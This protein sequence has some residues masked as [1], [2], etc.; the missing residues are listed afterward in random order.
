[1]PA[2]FRRLV[3]ATVAVGLGVTSPV[4]FAAPQADAQPSVEPQ[5]EPQPEPDPEPDPIVEPEPPV[6]PPEPPVEPAEPPADTTPPVEDAEPLE[7]EPPLDTDDEPVPE[8]LD[9]DE[10]ALDETLDRDEDEAFDDDYQVLRDSPE[11]KTARRWLAAG[12][13]ATISGAVLVGGAI[14]MSQ[15]APCDFTVGN[16]CFEDARD[17]GAVTLGAPGGLLLLGGIAM[18][19]VGGLQRRR[20]WHDRARELAVV[21]ALNGVLVTGRF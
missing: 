11:A 21:P 18:T 10:E 3:S 2:L 13:A 12:I 8:D 19:V 5:P 20:L 1:M 9:S 15:T 14:A 7:A 6:E 17:R 4:A 16:N